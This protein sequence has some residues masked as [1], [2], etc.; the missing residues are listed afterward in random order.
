MLYELMESDESTVAL[1]SKAHEVTEAT[2]LS[3]TNVPAASI[4]VAYLI[5]SY[6][7][8]HYSSLSTAG[9]DT[10]LLANAI[11]SAVYLK[12]VLYAPTVTDESTLLAVNWVLSVDSGNRDLAAMYLAADKSLPQDLRRELAVVDLNANRMYS[13]TQEMRNVVVFRN[14]L[15]DDDARNVVAEWKSERSRDSESANM[16][17]SASERKERVTEIIHITERAAGLRGS[18][19]ATRES[20]KTGTYETDRAHKTLTCPDPL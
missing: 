4:K 1:A 15:G 11:N 9:V 20:R 2:R 19:D 8:D 5:S 6:V 18:M 17:P 3:P 10:R 14:A 13:S 16:V 7:K 12:E